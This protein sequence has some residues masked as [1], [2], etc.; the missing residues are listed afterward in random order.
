MTATPVFSPGARAIAGLTGVTI[1]CQTPDSSIRYTTNGTTPTTTNGKLVDSG[2]PVFIV[3][4]TTL[5]AKAW[6][7]I[8]TASAVQSAT[9]TAL[10]VNRPYYIAPGT[11]TV[12]GDLSE[13]VDAEWTPLTQLYDVPLYPA[14]SPLSPATPDVAEAY[15]A[16]RWSEDKVYVAIKVRDTVHNLSPTY[17]AWDSHDL[18]EFC[19]HTTGTGPTDYNNYGFA[20]AQEYLAGIRPDGSSVWST[21]GPTGSVSG[22]G[23]ALAG[24]VVGQWLNYEAGLIPYHSLNRANPSQSVISYLSAGDV[25]GVDPLVVANN[26]VTKINS[27]NSLGYTGMRSE[28]LMT[29]KF[30]DY[31][32]IGKH[33]LVMGGSVAGVKSST[34]G[35]VVSCPGLVTA[36]FGDVFYVESSDRLSGIRVR[37]SGHGKSVGY[38][39]QIIGAV[40]TDPE[41][42]ERYI[43]A[44]SGSVTGAYRQVLAPLAMTNRSLGG[45]GVLSAGLNNVGLYVRTTGRVTGRGDGWFTIDD[46]SGVAVKVVGSAPSGT[47]YVVVTGANSC[48]KDTD[49]ALQRRILATNVTQ[50]A[51]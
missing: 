45:S 41:T 33:L 17:V 22:T 23:V 40:T 50:A 6:S 31:N 27:A 25:I 13:W 48:E 42:G 8:A 1:T 32:A 26:G 39:V 36:V 16:T 35:T 29:H 34:D 11:A 49:G 37:K 18:V 5:K 3:P 51:P 14:G 47:P 46:G 2:K 44:G 38:A 12:D 7:D 10:T 28:N 21:L 4:G 20:S 9:Y 24:K 19:I 43:D 30:M 15:Y